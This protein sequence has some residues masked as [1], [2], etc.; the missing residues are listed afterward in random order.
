[1]GDE[2][3]QTQAFQEHFKSFDVD[4]IA[5]RVHVLPAAVK[6]LGTGIAS[7]V[8]SCTG[9][10]RI[11]QGCANVYRAAQSCAKL[12]RAAQGCAKVCRAA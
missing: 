9:L 4:Y 10:R 5:I 8:Q 12:H 3:G 6:R 2:G 11:V 7:R 1:M